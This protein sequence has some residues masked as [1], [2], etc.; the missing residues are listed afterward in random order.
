MMLRRGGVAGRERRRR[1]CR[2]TE[3]TAAAAVDRL[4]VV[5]V[6]AAAAGAGESRGERLDGRFQPGHGG[7]TALYLLQHVFLSS[8]Q[9]GNYP[10]D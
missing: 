9:L 3:S 5:A 1:R 7:R 10:G 4:R 8:V 6:A 2:T